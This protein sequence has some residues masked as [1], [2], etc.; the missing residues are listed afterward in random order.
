MLY[1]ALIVST[2]TDKD[3]HILI[4]KTKYNSQTASSTGRTIK[5]AAEI[6]LAEYD[7]TSQ[8]WLCNIYKLCN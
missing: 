4:P 8:T 2:I 1:I 5:P 7:I 3:G 6:N